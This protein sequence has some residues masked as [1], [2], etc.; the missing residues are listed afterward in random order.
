[1]LEYTCSAYL[2]LQPLIGEYSH[3]ELYF[4]QQ[5]KLYFFVVQ[6]KWG[7]IV[8]KIISRFKEPNSLTRIWNEKIYVIVR[9]EGLHSKSHSSWC[10]IKIVISKLNVVQFNLFWVRISKCN[11]QLTHS[12]SK[13][14]FHK[15]I[16]ANVCE[17]IPVWSKNH[18][19]K[20]CSVLY[21]VVCGLG[22]KNWQINKGK[23][24]AINNPKHN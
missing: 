7:E 1:M 15:S 16:Q 10:K 19:C 9:R 6:W 23:D 12:E 4:N 24:V 14:M 5:N 3:Y 13:L 18:S 2:P 8:D 20:Y 17:F 22:Y 11:E 21:S